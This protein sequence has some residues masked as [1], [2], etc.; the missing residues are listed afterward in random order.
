MASDP[1]GPLRLFSRPGRGRSRLPISLLILAALIVLFSLITPARLIST[2]NPQSV[3]FPTTTPTSTA[4]PT[5]TSVHGGTVVFTCTR[6]EVNQICAINADGSGYVQLTRGDANKYYPAISPQGNELVF[7]QN[8]GDY[9][10]LFRINLVANVAPQGAIPAPDQITFYVG[11]T[12]SPSFSP[13]GSQILFVNRVSDKPT[14]LWLV[15]DEGKDAHQI[16]SSPSE[17]VG[18]AWAPD[19]S[20]VAMTMASGATFEYEV[21]LL[22]LRRPGS[23][24]RQLSDNLAGI[25]GSVAWSPDGKSLLVFA[26][27][28]SAREIYRLDSQNGTATQLT[29]GGNNA[30]PAYSPDGRYVVFNSLRNQGQA[31]LYIMRSDGHSQRQLT[32]NPE[33]D[34]Q[35]QWG[36]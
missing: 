20:T 6:Q 1:G 30:S 3:Q 36:P 10:D 31:D 8:N 14:S 19:G 2:V 34:W 7:V 15:D 12:F 27:P 9:F 28:V 25:G 23:A 33:P 32:S 18:A 17:I 22:D 5:P 4:K 35:P 21:F 24:P 16:Y 13:N 11:N 29:F 26:G